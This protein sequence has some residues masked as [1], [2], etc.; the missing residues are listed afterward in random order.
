MA[1]VDAAGAVTRMADHQ[2]RNFELQSE[3]SDVITAQGIETQVELNE[4]SNARKTVTLAAEEN[5][6]MKV[7]A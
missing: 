5:K 3:T 1:G 6:N 7:I 2:V 4:N